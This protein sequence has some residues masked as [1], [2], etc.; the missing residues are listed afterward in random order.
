MH[1]SESTRYSLV[2]STQAQ[3]FDIAPEL[4]VVFYAVLTVTFG[5]RL[6]SWLVLAC[7][8]SWR[9]HDP[10]T[11]LSWILTLDSWNRNDYRF[12]Q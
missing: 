2:V 3:S 1:Y 12:A 7:T 6:Y 11:R 8:K 5:N 4:R 10:F 9:E